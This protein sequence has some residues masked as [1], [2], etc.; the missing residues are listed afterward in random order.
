MRDGDV[1]FGST[2]VREG[3][4]PG[5]TTAIGSVHVPL[6]AR[7]MSLVE[8]RRG[9]DCAVVLE[10]AG[11]GRV[12]ARV[13]EAVDVQPRDLWLWDGDPRRTGHRKRLNQRRDDLVGAIQQ[14][15]DRPDSPEALEELR[16]LAVAID[17]EDERSQV[18]SR[19]LLASFVRPNHP[20]IALLAREAADLLGRDTQ[21]ASFRL[22]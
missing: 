19:S 5:G 1:L 7:V 2:V 8:E 4:F 18:L 12:L 10:E 11:T 21:D 15:P 6:S 16:A 22:S 14:D 17:Q 3:P 13:D 9:A 20:E